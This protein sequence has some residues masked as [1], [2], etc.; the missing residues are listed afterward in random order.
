LLLGVWLVGYSSAYTLLQSY[1]GSTFFNGFTFWNSADPTHGYVYYASETQAQQWGY[2]YTSGGVVYIH[3]DD[4]A[5]SSG[6]G[7]GSV[8]ITSTASFSSNTL[9]VFDI[10]HMPYGCGTWPAVWL[11]GPNWP[12]GGEVDIIE[13]VNL[14]QNNQM[15]LHTSSG[16][17]MSGASISQSGTSLQTNCDAS[18]NSN[19]GCGVLDSRTSSYGS[20][21]NA[22]GGGVFVAEWTPN[23]IKIFFFPRNAIPADITNGNP[24]PSGWGTPAA[25][26]PT[27]TNCPNS[28]FSNLQIVV[29]N[30]FCGD[31]AGSVYGSSGCPST[32]QNYVQNNPSDFSESYWAI[33]SF[34][35]YQ[36][37]S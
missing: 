16:C 35:V 29:D 33:N 30:T 28:H 7:R 27:G 11:V 24:S 26:F 19:S 8:R 37:S 2:I 9:F 18:V 13:G 36:S 22:N 12:N 20:G 14:N 6:S 34:K 15:T 5:V 31:W 25:D 10:A 21:F 32:C 1:S 23:V 3:S 17:S 4:T